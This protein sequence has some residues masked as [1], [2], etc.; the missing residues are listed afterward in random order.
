MDQA[1]DNLL[2]T[3]GWRRFNWQ[4]ILQENAP[5]FKFLPE[6]SG[7]LLNGKI[8]NINVASTRY[9]KVYMAVPGSR[10]QFYE[11]TSDTS[12]HFMFNTMDFYGPNEVV[13][14]TNFSD[15][16]SKLSIQSPFFE[17]YTATNTSP[18]VM[19]NNLLDE[20][21]EHN[22]ATQ[23]LN[24]YAATELKKIV[25]PKVDSVNF[26]GKPFKTYNFGEFTR[27][28]TMEESLRE[29]VTETF[30]SKNQKNYSIRLLGQD[31]ALDDDPLVLL[32][33]VPYFN[34]NRAM[35]IDPNKI[36]K[37]EIVPEIYHYG[38]SIF[39]GILNFSSYKSNLANTEINP[40]AV[41]V[42]YEGMQLQREFYSPIYETSAQLETRIP[43]FRNV[44]FWAP[45]I[46]TDGYGKAQVNFYSGDLKGNYVGIVNGLSQDGTPG[47]GIF[48]FEIK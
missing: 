10:L 4:E 18:F 33:G 15:T 43:D 12:G 3:Q 20:L 40:N 44:L 17:K 16:V 9:A 27:F 34:M 14:Q 32:D 29:F 2:L 38:S 19:N 46:R 7:H 26:Y 36:Q 6:Y 1:L 25:K 21:Q 41:V 28:K 23:V 37:L 5:Q 30:V 13:V 31:V 39:S 35:G 11:S 22:V 24:S 8:E 48:R 47:T 45:T 42:D